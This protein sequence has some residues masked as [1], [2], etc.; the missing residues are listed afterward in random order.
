MPILEKVY[1]S[2]YLGIFQMTPTAA[3]RQFFQLARPHPIA[4][5]DQISR[6]GIP[7]FDIESEDA[8]AR[9]LPI[10]PPKGIEVRDFNYFLDFSRFRILDAWKL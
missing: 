6:S 10:G 7:H 8:L 9:S 2:L 3:A 4:H 5:R 1:I